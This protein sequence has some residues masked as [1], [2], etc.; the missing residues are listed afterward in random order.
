MS[1]PA[2][3]PLHGDENRQGVIV[4]TTF[5]VT[6]LASVVVALRM[7]TRIWIVRNV[8]WDDYTI[9][10]ANIGIIIGCALVVVQV[11]Y[12]FGRHRFFL[13]ENEFVQLT[14]TVYSNET[15]P[16]YHHLLYRSYSG[17]LAEP[18]L[19][20][21]LGYK[22]FT[23]GTNSY[24]S[25]RSLR[26]SSSGALVD[27]D[28][29]SKPASAFVNLFR[30]GQSSHESGLEAATHTFE[31]EASRAQAHGAGGDDFA[32]QNLHGDKKTTTQ[33]IQ[34]TTTIDIEDKSAPGSQGGLSAEEELGE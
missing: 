11:Y 17:K 19:R 33:S 16:H 23:S 12:G 2:P 21:K 31:V 18:E 10:F 22:V 8:G 27:S 25:H 28:K 29:P 7:A 1:S 30:R 24:L 26:I 13:S 34:K 20:P 14:K 5:V 3:S 15:R 9:L 6:V 32:M 4:I